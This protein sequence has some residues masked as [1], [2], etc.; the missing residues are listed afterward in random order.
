GNTEACESSQTM[1]GFGVVTSTYQPNFGTIFVR[2]KPWEE[3]KGPALHVRGRMAYL[4]GEV[5][6][7][8]E[9]I[10]F[11]F[12]IPTIAGFGASAGFNFLIQDRSGSKSV[13]EL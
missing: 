3:R 6:K 13:E 12:N 9:A 5:A 1:G 8:P 2:L 10:I 7:I 4:F 11:P